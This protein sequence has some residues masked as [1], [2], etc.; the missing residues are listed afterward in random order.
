MASKEQS[1]SVVM[2]YQIIQI[3]AYYSTLLTS[4]K[5]I[6]NIIEMMHQRTTMPSK[7]DDST[8]DMIKITPKN[9][10]CAPF[11]LR[12]KMKQPMSIFSNRKN[13][14]AEAIITKQLFYNHVY[15][16]GGTTI[17]NILQNMINDEKLSSSSDEYL[18]GQ[19]QFGEWKDTIPSRNQVLKNYLNDAGIIFSSVP[20][21]IDKFLSAFL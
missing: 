21:P 7:C 20:D 14:F 12:C 19:S 10:N 4:D 11:Y 1:I 2:F 8:N 3:I 6:F 17:M 15:K 13:W 9:H 18:N 5:P 16:A